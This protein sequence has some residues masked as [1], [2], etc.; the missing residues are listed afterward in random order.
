[1]AFGERQQNRQH[2]GEVH[3]TDG[4]AEVAWPLPV[5]Q[6]RDEG[7]HHSRYQD[8]NQ[9]HHG[10]SGQAEDRDRGLQREAGAALG[11]L[12]VCHAFGHGTQPT[13]AVTA[14]DAPTAT[15]VAKLAAICPARLAACRGRCAALA[16]S[17]LS[18]LAIT[19]CARFASAKPAAS[20]CCSTGLSMMSMSSTSLPACA[21]LSNCFVRRCRVGRWW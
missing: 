6:Q 4:I 9:R 21:A 7:R 11:F 16:A 15:S 18:S 20:C 3:H 14:S 2:P 13:I 17:R 1:M 19:L 5:D 10:K 8:E 12:D